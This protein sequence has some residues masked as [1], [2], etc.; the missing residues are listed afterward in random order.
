MGTFC[1]HF[2]LKFQ[3]YEV[4]D[5]LIKL[6]VIEIVHVCGHFLWI[7]IVRFSVE[8]FIH[9]LTKSVFQKEVIVSIGRISS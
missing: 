2:L 6:R 9:E 3:C 5:L 4:T 1:E 7:A 8:S